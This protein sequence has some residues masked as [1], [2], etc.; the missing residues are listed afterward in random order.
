M[1]KIKG[2]LL[3]LTSLIYLNNFAQPPAGDDPTSLPPEFSKST[4]SSEEIS[5]CQLQTDWLNKKLKLG[6]ALLPEVEKITA[7]YVKKRLLLKKKEST[8]EALEAGKLQAEREHDQSLKKILTDKQYN[9]YLKQKQVLENS[10][11]IAGFGA[12][13]PP[14]DCKKSYIN[15]HYLKP[16]EKSMPTYPAP[17]PLLRIP[18]GSRQHNN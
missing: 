10:F 14:P 9:R 18:H 4:E 15:N 5:I 6:K 16:K 11:D 8:K 13:P 12:M 17:L 1:K 2:L 7:I 3:A